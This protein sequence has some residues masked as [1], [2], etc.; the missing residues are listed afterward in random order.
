MPETRASSAPSVTHD[1]PLSQSETHVWMQSVYGDELSATDRQLR[2][3]QVELQLAQRHQSQRRSQQRRWRE[4]SQVSHRAA[5][6]SS[7]GRRGSALI[8]S[9]QDQLRWSQ[10]SALALPTRG[11]AVPSVAEGPTA[12]LRARPPPPMSGLLP[13]PA[14]APAQLRASM[15]NARSRTKVAAFFLSSGEDGDRADDSG[16][17]RAADWPLSREE[18][19]ALVLR[20]LKRD[21]QAAKHQLGRATLDSEQARVADAAGLGRRRRRSDEEGGCAPTRTQRADVQAE[22]MAPHLDTVRLRLP[23]EN[24]LLGRG[25]RG[26]WK[27]PA[28]AIV[29]EGARR[30]L[31]A[32]NG[33]QPGTARRARSLSSTGGEVLAGAACFAAGS[34]MGATCGA[35]AALLAVGMCFYLGSGE[36]TALGDCAEGL[37]QAIRRPSSLAGR[38]TRS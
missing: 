7:G 12:P 10:A 20:L 24:T 38:R 8:A 23:A 5:V 34:F 18:K 28:T 17:C 22:A 13:R 37:A 31:L 6:A 4:G 33:Q 19:K 21:L 9:D 36:D 14:P 35:P 11:R 3:K 32:T 30:R 2:R 27:P 29:E 15:S 16:Q 25:T 26:A 1:W